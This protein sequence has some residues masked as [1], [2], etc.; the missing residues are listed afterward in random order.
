[1][2]VVGEVIAGRYRLARPLASGGMSRIWLAT[3]ETTTRIG[4]TNSPAGEIP[5]AFVVLKHCAI[6]TGLPSGQHELVRHWSLPEATAAA[7]VRHPNVIHT[8][9]VL[10]SW[11]GPWIIMEHLPSRTLHQVVDESGPLPAARAAAIGLAVLAGLR[12]AWSTGILHLDVKPGNVLIAAD[13][14]AVLTDF[15]PAVTPGGVRT[16]ADAG[17]VL[18]SPKW[19]APE[20]I[21]DHSSTEAS[22]LWSLGAT[23]YHAVEGRP[24]LLR[25]TTAQLLHALADPHPT[26]PRRAGPL[27]PVLAGLL[28]RSP[29]DRLTAAEVEQHLRDIVTPARRRR[30]SFFSGASSAHTSP[31]PASAGASS[32]GRR[33]PRPAAR[34]RRIPAIIAAFALAVGLTAVAATAE[35]MTRS[36]ES[37]TPRA[38]GPATTVPAPIPSRSPS[39]PVPLPEGFTW[40]ADPIGYR[41]AVPSG[42]RRRPVPPTGGLTFTA[43]RARVA[44]GITPL[45]ESP[46]DVVAT[47]AAAERASSLTGYQR[48]RIEALPE[49]ASAV[50]EYTFQDP[51]GTGMR[52][53]QR[54]IGTAT[55][56]YVLEW[57]TTRD[58]WSTELNRFT[59]VL[60]S[61]TPGP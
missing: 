15:G 11:D 12:A 47:L 16:L 48:V 44:M 3:D 23:L 2:A 51:D 39:S 24:P 43:A 53:V 26:Q 27:T 42:W 40:W 33:E 49:P 55:R 41:V 9:A 13:G 46:S 29:A 19:I 35:G 60:A 37:G 31:F 58:D 30:G 25:A 4:T 34:R 50:W 1:M 17:I 22:D 52:A 56:S 54:I 7:R 61:F 21:F 59:V 38:P 14:Q 32:P 28:R 5:P 8:H 6:P 36:A 57:R 45:A 10:P 20:R 18:G